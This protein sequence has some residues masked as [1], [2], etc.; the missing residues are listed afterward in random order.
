LV[1]Q[2]LDIYTPITSDRKKPVVIFIYGG[3]WQTGA[4]SDYLFVGETLASH[5]FIAV[6]P[7]YRLY[8]EVRYPALPRRWGESCVLDAEASRGDRRRPGL[9]HALGREGPE[10]RSQLARAR[11]RLAQSSPPNLAQQDHRPR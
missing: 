7:D 11:R 10:Q 5:G 2:K 3:N 4:K 8:P 9:A 1:R 6:I